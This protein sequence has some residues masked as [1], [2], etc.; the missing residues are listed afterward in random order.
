MKLILMTDF[1]LEQ[2]ELNKLDKISVFDFAL[3]V[4]NYAQF[5]KKPLTLGMFVPCDDKGNVLEEP[6]TC[7]SG[8]E[9][10]CMGMPYNYSSNEELDDYLEAEKSVL[11][12]GWKIIH[13]DKIRIT[14]EC[15]CFQL[16]WAIAYNSFYHYAK[17]ENLSHLNFELTETAIKQIGI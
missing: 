6:K 14:I 15:D 1:V 12:E 5:L 16:D 8:R 10:G 11:F 3:R 4:K 7:C 2:T 13:Q 17:I 9:C